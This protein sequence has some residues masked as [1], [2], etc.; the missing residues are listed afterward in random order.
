ML[1]MQ[2]NA[3]QLRSHLARQLLPL[4]LVQGDDPLLVQDACRAIRRK[5]QQQGCSE[6]LQF[7]L[8]NASKWESL[9]GH[10]FNFS[11]FADKQLIEI[12]LNASPNSAISQGLKSYA[13]QP[14][15]DKILLLISQK[16]TTAQLQAAWVK[17]IANQGAIVSVWPLQAHQLPQWLSQ[18]AQALGF[19]FEPDA[20]ELLADYC[21]GNSLA[22]HQLLEKL[23]L[24]APQAAVSLA[25]V[26]QLLNDSAR[27]TVFELADSCLQGDVKQAL[28]IL[29]KLQDDNV[30]PVLIL[31]ALTREW[32]ELAQLA[33]EIAQGAKLNAVLAQRKVNSKKAPWF[34][35]LLANT[36]ATFWYDLLAQA[37]ILDLIIKGMATGNSWDG[38]AALCLQFATGTTQATLRVT[39]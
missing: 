23:R 17:A 15:S 38:L 4:Y 6:R 14:S 19:I 20:L 30:E 27:Y 16:L 12:Q 33:E 10:L 1:A 25:M 5:A 37:A 2:I 7:S 8:D 26:Q 21:S 28:R 18:R 11:L 39:E 29:T 35:K 3:D 34:S 36:Q 9:Q 24:L 22:A 31:W 13:Q 32:R